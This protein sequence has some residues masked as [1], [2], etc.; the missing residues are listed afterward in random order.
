M[1]IKQG[2]LQLLASR[3]MDDVPE[4]GAG[5]SGA[6]IED[7]KSN[8]IMPDISES[9]RARGRVNM[10]QLH[11]AVR[12]DDT[13]TY[14]GANVIVAEPPSDPNVS[15]TLFSTDGVYDTR[16][17]AQA[18]LEAYL[19]KSAEWPGFL[20]EDHIKGQRQIQLFQRPG[21][22][23]P[24]PG[25]TLALVLNEGLSNEVLQ[26]VR[27]IRVTS[28][29]RTFTYDTD[30]DYQALVVTVEISDP[31]RADFTGTSANRQFGRAANGAKVRDTLAADAASYVGCSPLKQAA[32]L[33]SYTAVA[34]SIYTQLVPSSQSETPIAA[35]LPYASANFPVEGSEAVTYST[36]QT[37]S[38]TVNLSLLGGC[39]PGSLSIGVGS[40]KITDAGG[41]LMLGTQ[42]IGTIDYVNGILV[43]TSGSYNGLKTV[44]YRP[45]AY[46]LRLPQTAEILVTAETRS[47]SYVRDILPVPARGT[48]SVHYQ[49][50]KR[51][52]TLT[53]AGDGKLRGTDESMG[54]GTVSPDTGSSVVT[55]GALPDVGSAIVY[56][57]SVPTQETVQPAADIRVA[58]VIALDIPSERG[59]DAG[60]FDVAWEVDGETY[61]AT[62]LPNGNLT[63]AADGGVDITRNELTIA[64][65]KLPPAGTELTV[66]YDYGDWALKR[67]DHPARNAQGKIELSLG[68]GGLIAGAV[69]IEWNTLTDVS[70]LGTFTLEE[71]RKMGVTQVDPVNSAREDGAGKLMMGGQEIGTVDLAAGKIIFDPDVIVSL[72]RPRYV[73]GR[74]SWVG[75]RPVPTGSWRISYS[76]MEYVPAPSTYPNDETGW[77]KVSYRA[78]GSPTRKTQKLLFAPKFPLIAGLRAPIVPG[79]VVL[80]PTEGGILSDS[81]NGVLRELGA[82]GWIQ[83]GT[84]NYA[85]GE[86]V[87]SSW[88]AGSSGVLRRVSAVTTL[89]EALCSAFFFRTATAPIRPGSLS[90]QF[91]R[92]SGVQTATV[93]ADGQFTAPGVVGTADFESGLVRLGFGA[94][95]VAA[96]HESEPWYDA[97][98]VQA[99]GKI[100]RPDPIVASALRYSGVAYSYLPLDAQL[101]GIDPVRLPS[102]GRVPMFRNGRMCVVGH[103]ASTAQLNV[104]NNQTIDLGRVRL[105]RVSV[106]D[107]VGKT[108]LLGYTADLEAGRISFVD[109]SAMAMPIVVKHRIEDY[110]M[111]TD[112]QITGEITFNR[113]LTHD[114]PLGSY[115]SG[116]LE[117]GDRHARVS[118]VFA[119]KSWDGSSFKDAIEGVA[120]VAKY[121]QSR[122]PIEIT[123]AGGTTERWLLQFINASQYRLIGESVGVIATGDINS[124]LSPPNPATGKPFMT[125]K[126][127]GFSSGWEPGNIVRINTVGAIYPLWAVRTVQA[128][129]ESS[130]EHRFTL[131]ARGDVDRP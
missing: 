59:L 83:R 72:P 7:G 50:Q 95:V 61:H 52:Y 34:Q 119:Q 1:P 36:E 78:T 27:A 98:A 80:K 79:S 110:V 60:Y 101:L 54:A 109:T 120:P 44:T 11:L 28:V 111:A 66:A 84:L 25:K 103:Q 108:H 63:G 122:A 126:A 24:S 45:A 29:L 47:M 62:C 8:A 100:F 75:G 56:Q 40:S 77:V 74:D 42:Q 53:D 3:V 85:T 114:Y 116:A 51:W 90:V 94:M 131:L 113:P 117:A 15:I 76:G 106:H 14:M 48:L 112:V 104:S 10:R 58:Q 124:D 31:L 43:S 6:V 93:S 57:W 73:A 41:K 87:L 46:M 67:F 20:Y 55:L 81:G 96:G 4:G 49:V 38:S 18:R 21:S 35:A 86:A 39:A 13:D 37:W 88:T 69:S 26:Y 92:S 115:I 32:A 68:V 2:D 99:D 71:I 23:Q 121:D 127:L 17:Q 102:D 65:H 16:A 33:G 12:T 91:P 107:A 9:D 89:G 123:N 105:S 97:D 30:K 128:G 19:N 22:E 82:Q 64:P 118:L 5:P 70:V 130:I 125:I 129:P